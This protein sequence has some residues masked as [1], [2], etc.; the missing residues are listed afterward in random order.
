MGKI[1][2]RIC[3]VLV[4]FLLGF[5]FCFGVKNFHRDDPNLT[6]LSKFPSQVPR[7]LDKYSIESLSYRTPVA[8]PIVLEQIIATESAYTVHRYTFTSEG[9]RVSGLAHI[10]KS[11]SRNEKFPVIVQIRGYVDRE[12]YTSGIGTKR[13][14][15]VYATRGYITLAPDFL[16]YANSD[17]ADQDVLVERFQTYTVALDMLDVLKSLPQADS[18]RIALW[19]HSNGG[20]IALTLLAVTKKVYPTVLWAPVSKRFPY[21]VLYFTDE[22]PDKGKYLRK[23][24]ADFEELYDPEKY[25]FINFVSDIN[26]PIQLHQGTADDAVPI[27]WSNEFV[28]VLKKEKKDVT[29][30]TYAGADHNMTNSEN[31]WGNVVARDIEFFDKKLGR[32]K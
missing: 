16:G 23:Q 1:F 28:G 2:K 18:E 29:Y 30:F 17:G 22:L 32:V 19:G 24:I 31:A 12:I 27:A 21:S 26:G 8:G 11:S 5:I 9:K 10:P 14:S 4:G 20:H 3:L 13:S 6:P 15:A 7:M 25:S